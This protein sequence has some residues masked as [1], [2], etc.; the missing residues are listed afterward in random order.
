MNAY[1][2]KRIIYLTMFSMSFPIFSN[3]AILKQGVGVYGRA[4]GSAVVSSIGDPSAIYWNPAGLA[5]VHNEFK[6]YDDTFLEDGSKKTNVPLNQILTFEFFS[7]LSFLSLQREILFVGVS[8]TF[9]GGTI[10]TGL[11][12]S[13]VRGIEGY[14]VNANSIGPQRAMTFIGYLGYAYEFKSLRL[15]VNVLG[16]GETLAKTNK[17]GGAVDAGIQFVTSILEAGLSIH[18]IGITQDITS[19]AGYTLLDIILRASVAIRIFRAP[20]KL[21][22]GTEGIFNINNTDIQ[23]NVGLLVDAFQYVSFIVGLKN[24]DIAGSIMFNFPY[25]QLGYAIDRDPLNLGLQHH[26]QL[27]ARF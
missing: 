4:L 27:Q 16:I 17:Y 8:S 6:Q 9:V 14:D 12:A 19:E 3:V 26:V 21:F 10:A 20:L 18:N 25:V 1:P 22:F 11:L 23:F 2:I 24:L 13:Q 5:H 15:G 7:S